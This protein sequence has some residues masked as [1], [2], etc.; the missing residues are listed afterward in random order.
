[1]SLKIGEVVVLKSGSQ[2]MT[3]NYV[4]DHV[5]CVWFMAGELK[6]GGFAQDC[7]KADESK[8]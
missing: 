5:D 2:P 1:M 4:G 3:V 6:N 8:F 7:L